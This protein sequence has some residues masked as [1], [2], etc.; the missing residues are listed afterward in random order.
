MNGRKSHFCRTHADGSVIQQVGVFLFVVA[1]SVKPDIILQVM[2]GYQFLDS[3]VVGSR[4][5][6]G[7]VDGMRLPVQD[8]EC[9]YQQVE[10]FA[11]LNS[12]G[13]LLAD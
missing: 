9:L 12:G 11:G 6:N 7:K 1:C 2:C 4:A 3:V 13:F 5:Y 8:G 10:L